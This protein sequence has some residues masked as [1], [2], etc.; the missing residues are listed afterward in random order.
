[1]GCHDRDTPHDDAEL[2][3]HEVEL[4]SYCIDATSVTNADFTAFIKATGYLT[5]A[6]RHGFSAVFH[7]A[8][9]AN[10]RDI[11][12][13]PGQ[14]PWWIPVAGANWRHPGGRHSSLD[15]LEN[16]PVVHVSWND[17]LAYCQWS[18][19]RLPTEAEWERAARGG[20][21][22]ARYPWGN[23][24]PGTGGKW[25]C[26]IWQGRFPRENLAEDG[27][28]TTAPAIAFEP[29]AWGLWQ[30]VGNVWEWCLDRF[31]ESY[32]SYSPKFDPR[33]A[34]AGDYRSLRGGSWMCHDSYCNRY[35][36]SARIGNTP[37]SSSQNVGFRTVAD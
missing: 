28:L 30:M 3:I 1:M 29:N 31:D 10:R 18:Q 6:E 36:N 21:E 24:P 13:Q 8:V 25:R 20:E 19:R 33:G 27:W 14:T 26:N 11:L 15:G 35:R 22:G 17:A 5:D 9:S 4:P 32:Y 23:A 37:D 34:D 7:L 2:P 16:H 12:G